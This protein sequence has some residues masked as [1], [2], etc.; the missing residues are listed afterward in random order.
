MQTPPLTVRKKSESN[1]YL[2]KGYEL[3]SS[4][5]KFLGDNTQAYNDEKNRLTPTIKSTM[6]KQQKN[7]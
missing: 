7:S 2:G 3:R 5:H 1:Y 4:I 6:K